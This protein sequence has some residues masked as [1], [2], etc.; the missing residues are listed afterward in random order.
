MPHVEKLQ[1]ARQLYLSA[2]SALEEPDVIRKDDVL[3]CKKSTAL[4]CI[5]AFL[6][7]TRSS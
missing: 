2:S 4:R 7:H 5:L 1:T 6:E 3:Y